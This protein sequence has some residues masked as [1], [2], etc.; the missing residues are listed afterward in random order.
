MLSFFLFFSVFSAE[1]KKNPNPLQN[2]IKNN[3][4]AL[5]Q[6]M[7]DLIHDDANFEIIEEFIS[8]FREYEQVKRDEQIE[9]LCDHSKERLLSFKETNQKTFQNML[10][11]FYTDGISIYTSDD[12][13]E[14]III[15]GL[16]FSVYKTIQYFFNN[17]EIRKRFNIIVIP[18]KVNIKELIDNSKGKLS[19][20]EIK[21]YKEQQDIFL[22]FFRRKSFTK[23]DFDALDKKINDIK[24]KDTLNLNQFKNVTSQEQK[25]YNLVNQMEQYFIFSPLILITSN[26]AE[27]ELLYMRFGVKYLYKPN[28]E[29]E[30]FIDEMI[31]YASKKNEEHDK[32]IQ[33]KVNS[34]TVEKVIDKEDIK[35]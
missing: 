2:I 32:N 19:A 27:P 13:K 4:P 20:D 26:K 9:K 18:N 3:K 31:N 7:I 5:K 10:K 35:I 29:K 22:A 24:S 25:L 12:N 8:K 1:T 21:L 23:E 34:T 11:T 28:G 30:V 16:D 14:S 17:K 15:I 33:S 6:A